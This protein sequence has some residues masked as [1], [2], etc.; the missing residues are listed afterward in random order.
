MEQF[1]L[2]THVRSTDPPTSHE[3]AAAIDITAQCKM[4]LLSYRNGQALLDVDAYR[5]AGFPP[6]ARDGQRCSDLRH[7]GLIARTGE[8]AITPSGKSGYLCRITPKGWAYLRGR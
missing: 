1:D 5:L 8:R 7:E 4:I 6:H 2:F 3:A